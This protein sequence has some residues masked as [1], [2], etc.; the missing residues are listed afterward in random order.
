MTTQLMNN[1]LYRI[2]L[3]IRLMEADKGKTLS[4]NEYLSEIDKFIIQ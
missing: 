4:L 2:E 3:G 1:R